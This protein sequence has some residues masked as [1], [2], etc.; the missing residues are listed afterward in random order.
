[1][2]GS[3]GYEPASWSLVFLSATTDSTSGWIK[4]DQGRK[5]VSQRTIRSIIKTFS[6][7][8][9][10]LPNSSAY[11]NQDMSTSEEEAEEYCR[12]SPYR[13][14]Q[15]SCSSG[16]PSSQSACFSRQSSSRSSTGGMKKRE[17]RKSLLWNAI[18]SLC[19]T[20]FLQNSMSLT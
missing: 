14:S 7:T 11:G 4:N 12:N 19:M 13:C 3:V 1:M 10:V 9:S 20:Q 6:V 2:H 15:A 5:R 8:C 18:R 16:F 17:S